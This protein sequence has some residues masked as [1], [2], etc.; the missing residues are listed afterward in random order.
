MLERTH[1]D[2]AARLRLVADVDL[3]RGIVADQH[4]GEPGGEPVAGF[5]LGDPARHLRAQACRNRL[6][7]DDR[8]R[9]AAAISAA[10]C[11]ASMTGS[12]RRWMRLR[13]LVWPLAIDSADFGSFQLRA[14]NA[15][16]AAFALPSSAGAVTFTRRAPSGPTPSIVSWRARGVTLTVTTTPSLAGATQPTAEV[17]P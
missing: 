4:H 10:I 1:A 6:A 13:R 11:R 17:K 15:M 5:D 14:S 9:H 7:V 12:P 3:A 8:C 16:T 2:L